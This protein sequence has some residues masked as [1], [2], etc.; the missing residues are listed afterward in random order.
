MDINKAIGSKILKLRQSAK[1]SQEELAARINADQAY[2]SRL[3]SGELNPTLET[4]N[5]I[6]IALEVKISELFL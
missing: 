1:I 6:S 4:L 2:I 5:N 3:E